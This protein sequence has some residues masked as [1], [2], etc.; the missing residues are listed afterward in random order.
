MLTLILLELFRAFKDQRV[1]QS[2]KSTEYF[3]GFEVVT[4][5]ISFTANFNYIRIDFIL[6]F[7]PH[8]Y[9]VSIWDHRILSLVIQEL[10]VYLH[11]I[12]SI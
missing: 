1:N 3:S 6:S 4:I 10:S 12:S 2:N 5:H 8:F 7:M 11:K 9:S